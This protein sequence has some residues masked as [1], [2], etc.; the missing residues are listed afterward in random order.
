MPR[1]RTPEG[2]QL[3]GVIRQLIHGRVPPAYEDPTIE[4]ICQTLVTIMSDPQYYSH[5]R[6]V[7]DLQSRVI[8]LERA[9]AVYQGRMATPPVARKVTAKKAAAKPRKVTKK[10]ALPYNVK[11][12]KKGAS[13]R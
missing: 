2:D 5:L 4:V 12:F 8:Q 13:G 10:P 11:Q 7:I 6:L 9:L 1:V 3:L